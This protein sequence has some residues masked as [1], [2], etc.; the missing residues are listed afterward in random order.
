MENE[1]KEVSICDARLGRKKIMLLEDNVWVSISPL[2]SL[3]DDF[4]QVLDGD[5][6]VRKGIDND[7]GDVP[8]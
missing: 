8:F 3:L 6:D 5:L 2:T 7:C 1:T 4:G